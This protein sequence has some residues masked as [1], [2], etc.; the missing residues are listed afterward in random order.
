MDIFA[1]TIASKKIKYLERNVSKEMK[2]IS[3]EN[4][5]SLK[6]EI[7]KL[8]SEKISHVH[9]LVGLTSQNLPKVIYRSNAIQTN[10]PISLYAEYIYSKMHREPQKALDSPN[11]SEQKE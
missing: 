3:N 8:E 5:K 9:G 11:N 1:F 7:E 10:I 6:K 4:F 2:D